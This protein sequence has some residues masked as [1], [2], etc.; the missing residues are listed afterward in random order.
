MPGDKS[1]SHRIAMLAAT[2]IGRS[3]VRGFLTSEDC[4]HTLRA[5]TSLGA[6]SRLS[7]TGELEILGTGGKVLQPAGLLDLGNSGTGIRLLTGL[8]SGHAIEATLTGDPSLC[9]RPMGRIADPLRTMGARIELTGARGTAPIRMCGGRLHGLDYEMPVA[10]AQV[11]SALLL[12]ALWAEGETR[13]LERLPTR[14][15]TER[16]FTGLGIPIHIEGRTITLTGGGA[17]GPGHAG[18]EW[19]V[20]GDFSSA[21]FWLVAAASRP[22]AD[23][24]VMGVGLNPRRTA[25]LDVLR[26]MGAE[27]HVTPK[28]GSE[29]WEPYGD[30]TVRGAALHGTEVGGDEVPNLIDELPLIA[31]AGALS[32]GDTIVRDAAELKVKESDRISSI[33]GNLQRIGVEIE[34]RPDGFLI[35]G[36]AHLN[37][38]ARMDSFGDH[39]IAM[40]MTILAGA[41][42]G[43]TTICGI[44]CIDTSYPGFWDD[45]KTLGGVASA[46]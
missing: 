7:D 27:V 15:H 9:S 33:T 24:T 25:L 2:A 43:P 3:T 19:T 22:D 1:I 45:L 40:A 42:P 37:S 10:S 20:P 13:I 4:M 6:D 41:A 29:R 35:H 11:K 34:A 14:D 21:A 23:I 16:L 5:M 12:A 44:D 46:W 39:R 30:I 38:D 18:G 26:R 32:E 8:L 31:V 17:A 36:R 28:T